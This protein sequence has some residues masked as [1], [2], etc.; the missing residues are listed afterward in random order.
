M[1]DLPKP[2]GDRIQLQQ[3]VLNLIRNGSEAMK[4]ASGNNHELVV[5]TSMSEPNAVMIAIR[6]AGP[7][8]G[9]EAFDQLFQPFY[10]TKSNGLGMGLFISR[11]IVEAHGGRLWAARNEDQGI[12]VCC[13][14]PCEERVASG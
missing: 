3:V 1:P 9:D 5:K 11:S 6:D 7:R 10:T 12:T 8:I 2:V 4:D 13:T 14:L